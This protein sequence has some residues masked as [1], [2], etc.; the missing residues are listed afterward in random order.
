M[1]VKKKSAENTEN[2]KAA[3]AVKKAAANKD[4]ATTVNLNEAVAKEVEDTKVA[5]TVHEDS[6]V[7]KELSNACIDMSS[8][9]AALCTQA[10]ALKNEFKA[11][12][13]RWAKELRS[14]QRVNAKRK[15]RTQR[16]P[17]GFVKPAAISDEL[18]DFLQKAKGSEMARTD[19]TREINA[20][21]R[22]NSLQDS[23]NG[24]KINA[25]PKLQKLLKLTSDDV[26]TYFN[27]QKYMSPHFHK[28]S[29]KA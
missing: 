18:A 20:Y 6:E 7:D 15:V 24:R 4:I 19:V 10:M 13:R 11:L 5:A 22:L 16:Q 27:L 2:V 25:D 21:I 17:S 1:V 28:N 8:K 9:L 3:K 26:L 23:E 14:L 29:A 12:E